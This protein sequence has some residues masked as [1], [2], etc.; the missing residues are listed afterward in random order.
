MSGPDLEPRER[1]RGRLR[2]LGFDVV[3]F[4]AVGEPR[5]DGLRA[6]LAAGHHADMAW[7]ERTADKRADPRRV[8][9]GARTVVALGVDY[10]PAGALAGPAGPWARYAMYDDYHDTIG[11]GLERAVRVLAE[12]TDT[13]AGDHRGYVD[14]GP[15]L[16]RGW[17]A[18]AGVGFIGKH[19]NL[20]S[21]EA[22]N[23]LLL[24]AVLSR[25]ELPPDP[26]LAAAFPGFSD[27]EPGRPGLLCGKCTRCLAACPTAAL[28][29]PGV[30]DARRCLSYH[31]IENRGLV[32]RELRPHFGTRL[33]GCDACLE[34]CPWNRFAQEGRL[35]QAQAHPELATPDLLELLSLDEGSFRCRFAGTPMLRAKRRGLLRNVCVALGNVG[36]S[37]ALPALQRAAA[38]PEPLIAEHA[39]WAIGQIEGRAA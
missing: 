37:A 32:P 12:E 4:A 33:F 14:A 23:W 22:G 20:I 34:V 16:E 8:L 5:G 7:L 35:M 25:A 13:A 30:V 31:T 24:A 39:R 26:P 1:L 2:A 19:G 3:R 15:V 9:P 21:R 28:P 38:D 27:T 6:W 10:G 18:A 11:S 36:D 29:A 17:A